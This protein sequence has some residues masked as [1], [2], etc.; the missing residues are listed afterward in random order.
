MT[1]RPTAHARSSASCG[2]GHDLRGGLGV[3]YTRW[4]RMPGQ[5]DYD[6]ALIGAGPGGCVTAALLN[7][8]GLRVGIF[9]RA[10]FPRFVIGESLLPRC[11]Q[12][13][14]EACLIDRVKDQ[15]YMV[16]SGALFIEGEQRRAIHFED[17]L[18]GGWPYTW[19]MPRADFDNVLAEGVQAAGVCIHFEHAVSG[20]EVG[21]APRLSVAGPDGVGREVRARFI[22]DASG[23]GRVL[24]RLLDLDEPSG[25]AMR[26]AL[27]SHIRGDSRPDEATDG[28]TW[29][30]VHP[31]G[32]WI[33]VIPFSNGLTSVGIVA[34]PAML[35]RYPDD[36]E[37]RLRAII[38]SDPVAA[39]YLSDFELAFEPHELRGYSVAVKRL[40]GDGF[41]LVGNATEFLD[42]I[43]SSGV[44]LAMESGSCAAGLILR[45]LGGDP[46]DWDTEYSEYMMRGVDTFRAF[47]E[48]WYDGSFRTLLFAP[49]P[50]ESITRMLTS[51]LAGQ[52][53]DLENPF[54]REPQRKLLQLARVVERSTRG[55]A[56][57]G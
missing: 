15:G 28:R 20:V 54:V 30:T 9:E 16:K 41:C 39:E 49:D 5:V 1:G 34:E 44:T 55:R 33:W 22:V 13:L 3:C 42:P 50:E 40:W 24:P 52:V 57:M 51:V 6:V 11:N 38:A 46:V 56:G 29:V 32:A 8:A 4:Q 10:R 53:W 31:E 2:T 21:A 14:D 25:L 7:K 12:R 18:K 36:G 47:V 27:F 43:F 19:Q 48:A 37:E 17:Q 23:Y 26:H 35:V 45:E